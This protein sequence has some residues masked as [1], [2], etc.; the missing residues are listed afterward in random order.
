MTISTEIFVQPDIPQGVKNA[1]LDKW[2]I[3]ENIDN[4]Q[5][6]KAAYVNLLERNQHLMFD[7]ER[8]GKILNHDSSIRI[9]S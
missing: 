4:I 6:F 1:F 8:S 3:L 2:V 9:G 5:I 7:E